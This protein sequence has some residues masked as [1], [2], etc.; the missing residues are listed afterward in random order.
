MSRLNALADKEP[1]VW[2][3]VEALIR[4]KQTKAYGEAV[5][6]LAQLRELAEH[7]GQAAEFRMR[8]QSLQAQFSTLSGLKSRM[9]AAR[10]IAR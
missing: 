7:R 1:A 9:I 3:Q 2:E 4:Q 8:V 6:L 5:S 10:L